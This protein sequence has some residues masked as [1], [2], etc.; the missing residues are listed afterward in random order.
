MSVTRAIIL[1]A[2]R[3]SRMHALTADRPKCLVELAGRPLLHWQLD[4]LHDGG[5]REVLVVRGYLGH[6]L[7]G[8]FQTLDNPDW[9]HSNM[10]TTL[11]KA[12][13]WLRQAPT[14]VAYSDILYRQEHISALAQA[15]G[16]LAMTYD[17]D[18]EALWRLRFQDPLSDAET[19]VQHDGFLKEIGSRSTRI[20]D[21]QGQYMG[22]LKL[23]PAGWDR[24]HGL[25]SERGQEAVAKLDVTALFRLL[26]EQGM[27]I[28]TVPVQGGWCEADS[29]DDLRAYAQ[30]LTDNKHQN[31]RWS[32]D[33]RIDPTSKEF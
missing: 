27:E 10:V 19:F 30:A 11:G 21:I 17:T 29:M 18:W 5:I 23:T 20:S 2:G 22:L 13:H 16:D 1:A 6:K 12:D 15:K 31:S 4:A 8:D 25:L 28:V 26:L 32:H 9:E 33:W 14:L 24:V 7:V 3:G